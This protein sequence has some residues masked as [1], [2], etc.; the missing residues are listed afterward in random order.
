MYS[1]AEWPN[2]LNK[3]NYVGRGALR[4]RSVCFTHNIRVFNDTPHITDA[5]RAVLEYFT[6]DRFN[7]WFGDNGYA[8][9]IRSL[10]A[11]LEIGSECGRLHV[12][13]Y[14]EFDSPVSKQLCL[15]VV[16]GLTGKDTYCEPR[17]A[18]AEAAKAYA[19]K[20]DGRAPDTEPLI[21]GD[22]NRSGQVCSDS[23]TPISLTLMILIIF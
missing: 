16:K 7:T 17:R 12:Q 1:D 5:D 23:L 2:A 18:S 13:A 8:A 19:T 3:W 14:G 20:L 22:W 10:A 11:Q 21:T 6:S 15:A 9:R 4:S